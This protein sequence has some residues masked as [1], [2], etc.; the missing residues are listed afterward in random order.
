M[1]VGELR[2]RDGELPL[3]IAA[4]DRLETLVRLRV[5]AGDEEAR[6]REHRAGVAA[7]RDEA[8]EPAQVRLGDGRVALEREDQGDVD[9]DALGDAVLDRTEARLG[10]RDLDVEVRAIDLLVEAKR[11]LEGA[12]A[13]VGE[14]RVDLERDEAVDSVRPLPDRAHQVAGLADVVDREREE[15][16]HGVVRQ[17]GDLAQL[18][19]VEVA[20]GEGLLED[21]RVRGDADDSV[22][23]DQ[24]GE[25]AGVEHLAR[26]RVDPDAHACCAEPVETGGISHRTSFRARPPWPGGRSSGRRR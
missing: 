6:D 11:L 12:L 5:D 17:R 8:L 3:Q 9:R 24:A 4:A 10:G 7:R 19:V 26:E 20:L 16:L 15:L 18:L 25:L 2:V 22:V 21:R 13:L 23:G 14:R 1:L